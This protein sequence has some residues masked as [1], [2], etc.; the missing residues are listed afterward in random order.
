MASLWEAM[1]RPWEKRL[2]E[3]HQ[4]T[5]AGKMVGGEPI[6]HVTMTSYELK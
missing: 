5:L 3:G 2:E 6:K 4:I 1:G